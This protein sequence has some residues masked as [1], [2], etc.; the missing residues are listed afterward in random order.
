[1]Q[2][3]NLSL[4]SSED[5]FQILLNKIKSQKSIQ[6]CGFT[7][8]SQASFISALN[9]Q[10]S[11]PICF[12]SSNYSNFHKFSNQIKRLSNFDINIFPQ[13]Q[14]SPLEGLSESESYFAQISQAFSQWSNNTIN[15]KTNLT[16]CSPKAL[17]LSVCNPKQFK[18]N[19]VLIKQKQKVNSIDL[20]KNLIELGYSRTDTVLEIGQF[21]VRGEIF[22][23]FPINQINDLP[24]RLTFFDDEIEN[25]KFFE[26]WTQRS[27]NSR[28]I[29]EY[30]ICGLLPLNLASN[31]N[32][33]ELKNKL[34]TFANE[35]DEAQKYFWLADLES[36]EKQ[37]QRFLPW[38]QENNY[39]LPLDY[40][41]Q[42]GL[43]ILDEPLSIY[44]Q[45]EQFYQRNLQELEHKL[46]RKALPASQK[47]LLTQFIELPLKVK[48]SLENYPNKLE[49]HLS[50]SSEDNFL[51]FKTELIPQFRANLEEINKYVLENLSSQ[52]QI[53]F[54]TSIEGQKNLSQNLENLTNCQFIEP[55]GLDKGFATENKIIFTDYELFN[56]KAVLGASKKHQSKPEDFIPLDLDSIREG[57][58]LVHL[59]HGI[60]KFSKLKLIELDK[61]KKEYITIE[62]AHG[63]LLNVP[64]E[65]MNLLTLYKGNADGQSVKVSRL[66]GHDW[67]KAK[68]Q[69]RAAVEEIAE[70]LLELYAKRSLEGGIN[71]GAD[72]PWQ[73]ELEDNFPYR[74]TPDQLKAINEIKNDMES[75]LVMD[76]LLCGDVGFGKTEVII[77]C[78][79]KAIM[80]GKQVAVLAPTTILAQQH[81]KSFRERFGQFPVKIELITRALSGAN[82]KA[83]FEKINEGQVDLVIGTHA[84]LGK[85]LSFKDLALIVIDEEQ[86]FGVTHKEKLKALKASV[87]VLTVSATPIPRTMHMA[88]SGIREMSLISTAPPGRVPIK[89]QIAPNNLQLVRVAIIREI[90]RGGQVFYLHNRIETIENKAIEL[91]K[92]VPEASFRIAHGR[93]NE[94]DI[95]ESMA[96]F[97]NHDFDVLLATSI[98]ENGLDIPNANT[99]IIENAD[100]LGL[101]QLYQLKGRVG[102]SNDPSRP[103][104]ALLLHAP[105]EKLNEQAKARL[106]AIS[107]YSHLGSGYQ[108]ALRDMEIRGIGN[109]LGSQQHGKMVS[110]GF[111]LYCEMLNEAI[112]KLKSEFGL[113]KNE[114]KTSS[115]P[116]LSLEEKPTFDLKINAYI[117]ID[118]IEDDTLRMK[119]YHRLSEVQ[120]LLQLQ[121]L[122]DEWQDR[123]GKIPTVVINLIKIVKLRILASERGVFGLI[124]PMG[125]FIELNI[126]AANFNFTLW[127]S[128]Q[129]NLPKWI[130]DKLALQENRSEN[131]FK[132]LIKISDLNSSDEQLELLDE[133]LSRL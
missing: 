31:D 83:V 55:I 30:N 96:A 105:N 126:K 132:I 6:V 52:R 36:F 54:S 29:T 86:K 1:M 61:Q 113:Q 40:F 90:E 17:S 63:D 87:S 79:F 18:N 131:K 75:G 122:K 73:Q 71:F 10:L 116:F 59:K 125:N 110:I 109:L 94:K 67:E 9:N 76:R 16:L 15:N 127:K 123:F 103:G 129:A 106:E 2:N 118:W 130:T 42:N 38:I 92:L 72:T 14:V 133:L 84:I 43:L 8:A 46:E 62:Y 56:K 45:L 82:K 97:H 101:S 57:D 3:T 24:I 5:K 33:D 95:S 77:R 22:D 128:L 47:E 120:S 58:F 99:M 114:T 117:P 78:A 89:T 12:I 64:V 50:E 4:W 25:L 20:A 70:E 74:E 104:Y 26:P 68:K 100:R 66:G 32:L 88:L 44:A 27:I 60:G 124:R 23:I 21:A 41:P 111:E 53:Y 102:R 93:M 119:E 11:Q 107:R 91:M 19:Q 13:S 51:D 69:A 49:L 121:A 80:A 81:F 85:G 28:E 65:Q 35:L 7:Q 108:I 98:I 39:F 115:K 48:L 112:N 34:R 37:F